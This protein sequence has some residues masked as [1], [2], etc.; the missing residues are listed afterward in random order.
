[1]S[2]PSHAGPAMRAANARRTAEG[3]VEKEEEETLW[4]W[5]MRR[6]AASAPVPLVY[7]QAMHVGVSGIYTSIHVCLWA[8][9]DVKIEDHTSILQRRLLEKGVSPTTGISALEEE[10]RGGC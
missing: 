6:V 4:L 7:T 5:V 2:S 8:A 1:M 3:E 10:R 9:R